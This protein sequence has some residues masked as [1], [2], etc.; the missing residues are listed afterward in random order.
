MAL[1]KLQ[2]ALETFERGA[3]EV[4]DPLRLIVEKAKVLAQMQ[5]FSDAARALEQVLALNPEDAAAWYNRGL[6]LLEVNDRE[7]AVQ[8]L[9][10]AVRLD[11][12]E[13]YAWRD[14]GVACILASTTAE[15]FPREAISA[16][17][18]TLRRLPGDELTTILL[19]RQ[20][21]SLGDR[22]RALTQIRRA[23][24]V[25]PASERL[26]ALEQEMA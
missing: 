11:P 10:E 14:L 16:L 6:Y 20:Y 21:Q 9:R 7:E 24:E 1:G 4:T 26:R 17:E 22:D 12:D 8:S 18:E 2:E 5:R 15:S 13:P 3:T 19:A 23:I 25:H